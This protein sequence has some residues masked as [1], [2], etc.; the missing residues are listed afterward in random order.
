MLRTLISL[1][2]V[3]F[4][5]EIVLAAPV[6]F[7]VKVTFT[8]TENPSYSVEGGIATITLT[9]PFSGNLFLNNS[10]NEICNNTGVVTWTSYANTL[11]LTANVAVEGGSPTTYYLGFPGEPAVVFSDRVPTGAGNSVFLRDLDG[12]LPN[13]KGN[14]TFTTTDADTFTFHVDGGISELGTNIPIDWAGSGVYTVAAVDPCPGT[15]G[16]GD[17][18]GDGDGGDGGSA[19]QISMP[20]QI[21]LSFLF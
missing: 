12:Q 2:V 9:T 10:K 19:G 15:G 8:I 14:F 7:A 4:L 21:L 5:L 1:I 17:G 18:D 3:L 20:H 16:D 11:N 13:F 6:P